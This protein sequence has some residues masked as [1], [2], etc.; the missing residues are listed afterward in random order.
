MPLNLWTNEELIRELVK[1]VSANLSHQ[2]PFID[3]QQRFTRAVV[4]E[5]LRLLPERK[6]Q[7]LLGGS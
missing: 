6:A 3:R 5:T 7:A 2:Y 4:C 1:R